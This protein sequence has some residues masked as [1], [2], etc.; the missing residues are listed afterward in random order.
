MGSAET[1]KLLKQEIAGL[2]FVWKLY[3][4]MYGNKSN[5][6]KMNQIS[7]TAFGIIQ[8]ALIAD[9]IRRTCAVSDPPS[10]GKHKNLVLGRLA[11][12]WKAENGKP[13]PQD[14]QAKL[15]AVY[16]ISTNVRVHRNKKYAHLDLETAQ[17]SGANLN[18]LMTDHLDD[19]VKAV[20]AAMSSLSYLHDGSSMAYELSM[21]NN[22]EGE[23]EWLLSDS[24]RFDSLRK[25]AVDKS[26]SDDV[27]RRLAARRSARSDPQIRGTI[28]QEEQDD[29]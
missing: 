7:G 5:V 21:I 27:F 11:E 14:V 1:A 8:R 20:F 16:T 24:L 28:E 2:A 29:H 23:M 6:L 4:A 15:D 10:N 17:L 19:S 26:I 12:E 9:L 13:L 25:M 3:H 22:A 18:K